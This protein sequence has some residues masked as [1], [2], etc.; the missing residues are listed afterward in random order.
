[1][2]WYYNEHVRR[3]YLTGEISGSAVCCQGTRWEVL[4]SAANIGLETGFQYKFIHHPEQIQTKGGRVGENNPSLC[5]AAV[6][7]GGLMFLENFRLKLH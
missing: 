4:T 6:C 5:F 7:T 1:M 2:N 3:D